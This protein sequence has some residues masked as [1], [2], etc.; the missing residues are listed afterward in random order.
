MP[1]KHMLPG[2]SDVLKEKYK[3]GTRWPIQENMAMM[4]LIHKLP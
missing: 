1:F 3:T 4:L 2:C